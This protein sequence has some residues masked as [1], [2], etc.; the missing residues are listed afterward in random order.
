[1]P[2]TDLALVATSDQLGRQFERSTRAPV[3]GDTGTAYVVRDGA[4][5]ALPVTV[6]RPIIIRTDD[7][8]LEQD[9]ERAGYELVAD[10]RR[11]DSG[12]AVVIHGKVVGVIWARSNAASNRGYAVDITSGAALI[13]E[14]R[15]AGR[16]TTDRTGTPIDPTRCA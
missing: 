11:G 16:I 1:D 8:Y 10:V 3:A 2:H 13:D 15:A 6:A 14:Q 5:T 9:T 7:I 12:G 4:V